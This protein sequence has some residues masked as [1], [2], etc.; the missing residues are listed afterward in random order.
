MCLHATPASSAS[1]ASSR[2]AGIA[3]SLGPVGDWIK[4]KNLDYR[5]TRNKK[6]AA[7][8]DDRALV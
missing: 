3:V 6:G 1:V 2:S 7:N 5:R 4:V 8:R